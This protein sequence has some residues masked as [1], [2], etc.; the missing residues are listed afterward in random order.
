[1]TAAPVGNR[2][3][4]IG[5]DEASYR[6]FEAAVWAHEGAEPAEEWATLARRGVEV[7]LQ[8]LGDG[9]PVLFVHG[10]SNCGTSWAPLASRLPGFRCLLLD[11]P[12]CGLSEP[13]TRRFDDVPSFA[14][15]ADTLVV[16]VLD[17]LGIERAAIVSTSLGGYFGL[18]A[19]A[20]HPD[21]IDRVAHMGWTIGAPMDHLPLVMRLVGAIRPLGRL[22]ARVP[23][24]EPAVRSMLAQIGLRQA[25]EAGRVPQAF[26]DWF[27][28]MLR[29]T[30]TVRND[31]DVLPPM[32]EL[33]GGVD[34]AVLFTDE[35]L[36]SI[37]VPVDFQWGAQDPMGGAGI[38]T[39]FVPRI[40][41]ATLRLIE[42]GGHVVWIDDPDDIAEATSSFLSAA[43]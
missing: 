13:L 39:D 24:P 37:R 14:S 25:L 43:R 18:R 40:R 36:A 21:R 16:D 12:G 22:M 2:L 20:A 23:L 33:T 41:G 1:M 11:R 26:V 29:H 32:F 34:D 38:A 3:D 8:V 4:A 17:A 10:A 42:G 9:P 30:H 6:G 28:A 15:F 27:G 35:L 7:R 31:T 5:V 19:A